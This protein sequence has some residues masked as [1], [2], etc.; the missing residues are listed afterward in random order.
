MFGQILLFSEGMKTRNPGP[1]S[2]SGA[3]VP[4]LALTDTPA[5]KMLSDT[6]SIIVI[7]TVMVRLGI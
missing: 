3:W 4:S 2:D 6:L 7:V 1:Q 5:F